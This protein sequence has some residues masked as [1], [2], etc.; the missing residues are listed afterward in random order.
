MCVKNL[1]SSFPL[2]P[3]FSPNAHPH[4]VYIITFFEKTTISLS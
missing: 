3:N 2:D 1:I 4:M